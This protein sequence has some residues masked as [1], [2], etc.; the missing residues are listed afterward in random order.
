MLTL[1]HAR[2][3]LG[4]GCPMTDEEVKTLLDQ[5]QQIALIAFEAAG[6]KFD[7]P[8]LTSAAEGRLS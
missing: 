6:A 1:S 7:A 5:L 2:R 3:L 8:T 4:D